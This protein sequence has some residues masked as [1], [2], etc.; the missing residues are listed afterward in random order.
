M[1]R[2]VAEVI[3]LEPSE[4][5]SAAQVLRDDVAKHRKGIS[6]LKTKL[7]AAADAKVKEAKRIADI[8]RR[9]PCL[10]PDRQDKVFMTFKTR[11]IARLFMNKVSL[12]S[13]LEVYDGVEIQRSSQDW[14]N[15]VFISARDVSVFED[16]GSSRFVQ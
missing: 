13:L 16:A 15:G 4:W 10:E 12:R 1:S 14:A 9:G 2:A 11:R 8:L 5:V 7:T 3:S 6:N